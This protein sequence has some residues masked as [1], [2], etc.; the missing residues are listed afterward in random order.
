MPVI[1]A[2]GFY[3]SIFLGV[4]PARGIQFFRSHCYGTRDLR[5]FHVVLCILSLDILSICVQFGIIISDVNLAS[6][7]CS[8]PFVRKDL[9]FFVLI[10]NAGVPPSEANSQ[11]SVSGSSGAIMRFFLWPLRFLCAIC[12][13]KIKI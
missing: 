4:I 8:P 13:R 9:P 7:R 3:R 6:E 1:F 10:S 5:K 11:L 2:V 12:G